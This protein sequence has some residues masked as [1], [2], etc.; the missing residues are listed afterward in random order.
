L[1]KNTPLSIEILNSDLTPYLSE[2]FKGNFY[3]ADSNYQFT[4]MCDELYKRFEEFR[5]FTLKITFSAKGAHTYYFTGKIVSTKTNMFGAQ[6][7][8]LAALSLLNQTS[9]RTSPRIDIPLSVFIYKLNETNTEGKTEFFRSELLFEGLSS[10]ISTEGMGLL[11][12]FE[13]KPEHGN[14]FV[15]EIYFKPG[16]GTQ[17]AA[18]LKRTI[19]SNS[20]FAF[21]YMHGFMFDFSGQL[22]GKNDLTMAIIQYLTDSK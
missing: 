19:N 22:T 18:N 13:I 4:I 9:I 12:D 16:R 14:M 8:E 17:V 15:A 7:I 6:L 3:D 11:S 2:S 1:D 5:G 20:T 21:K 10:D